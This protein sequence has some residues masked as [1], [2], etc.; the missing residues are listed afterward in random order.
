[1][2]STRT[3]QI[4]VY[5]KRSRRIID[6]PSTENYTY[7]VPDTAK[8]NRAPLI[9][10][11]KKRE[12]NGT[13]ASKSKPPSPPRAV[14]LTKQRV[15]TGGSP[16]KKTVKRGMRVAEILA[17]E[18]SR[19]QTPD[20][21]EE[22]MGGVPGTPSRTPL[23][24]IATNAFNSPVLSN[25]KIPMKVQKKPVGSPKSLVTTKALSTVQMN[26]KVVD[27]KGQT[28]KQ[29]QRVMRT[30][31]VVNKASGRK[32]EAPAA[33]IRKP[34]P[35]PPAPVEIIS[36]GSS[37]DE[38]VQSDV[39]GVEGTEIRPII[40]SNGS[41]T[42]NE[43]EKSSLNLPPVRQ[44][45][46]AV[47]RIVISDSEEEEDEDGDNYLPPDSPPPVKPLRKSLAPPRKSMAPAPKTKAPIPNIPKPSNLKV[48]VIV[49]PASYTL[50]SKPTR[51]SVPAPPAPTSQTL[52]KSRLDSPVKDTQFHL[53]PK[54]KAKPPRISATGLRQG[55][56]VI[57]S[58]Y[59]YSLIPSP[60]L[61]PRTLT[62]IRRG[63]GRGSTTSSSL[64]AF[65]RTHAPASP[66]S[67]TTPT[68]SDFDLSLEFSQLDIGLAPEE[69]EA[70]QLP[71]KR[72]EYPEYLRPLLE[73]CRQE[74]SGP[75]EFSAFIESFPFDPILQ[76]TNRA[77][78]KRNTGELLRF[79]K[80]G[81][82]SYSEVFGIGNV[83]LK[84]IP[85]RDELR[86]GVG[87]EGE[88]EPAPTDA[89]D[90]RK[91]IIVTRAMGEVHDRF[92]KLLKT[93]VV[94]GKYPEVLLNLWDE[95]HER[96]GSESV[97]PDMFTASQMYAII[98][99]PNDGLDLE[100][101]TFASPSKTGWRQA[102]SLFWQVAKALAH[103]EQLVS[104]EHRDLHWGQ[105][106]V[107]DLQSSTKSAPLRS[108]SHTL[109][110]SQV[111]PT[112]RIHMDDPAHGVQATIIDLGLSRMDAGDGGSGDRVHWTAFDEEVFMGEGD[113]QFDIY[114]LM[115]E[116]TNGDWEA[117][118]P[119]T[120]VM[121]LHYLITKLLR[122]KNLKAPSIPRKP[123]K[124]SA[125]DTPK[126][127]PRSNSSLLNLNT[128]PSTAQ[129][130]EK[131]CYDALVDI[132]DWLGRCIADTV[133]PPA[134]KARAKGRPRKT[135]MPTQIKVA[136]GLACVGAGEVV[137][138][139]V[140]RGW[141]RPVS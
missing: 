5:G 141:I 126:P 53:S 25:V 29:E 135:T 20:I 80:I 86:R 11:M 71:G 38:P 125:Q 81:E 97:R 85:L 19:F 42:A 75:Y 14:S 41:S 90:A 17:Q 24:T 60:P 79:R 47:A 61:K 8:S 115:R 82:A 116:C 84:V 39:Q 88:D 117:F 2:L 9:H 138:Y 111:G 78:G 105:V 49:P 1:M 99:L 58:R 34:R 102:S 65:G 121:W 52:P 94:R 62:P 103:A 93:Y 89:R 22:D 109:N 33:M 43:S 16:P 96:K 113:Y 101:Y 44:P 74:E 54:P 57:P 98:V 124:A 28:L 26:I 48:E 55:Q 32:S 73:E 140:K 120:N 40:L 13:A 128:A 136:D 87:E 91:E 63:Q 131:D 6:A 132:E 110:Q 3:K 119:L 104:F 30:D 112:A 10:R 64:F 12:N 7:D 31:I 129:F 133:S 23:S 51:T 56:R 35:L 114:R 100:A 4:N 46:R 77:F 36:I 106:L 95:Y 66:P 92:V 27:A 15:R 67:P 21:G 118:H 123:R 122:H 108:L 68:D 83:V 37:I 134:P 72:P 59:P 69:L 50:P 139:G 127:L 137:G 70:L 76:D 130:T 107:K 45:R 18:T